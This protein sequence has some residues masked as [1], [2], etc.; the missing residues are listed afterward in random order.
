MYRIAQA[1]TFRLEDP[2]ILVSKQLLTAEP[3]AVGQD[4]IQG[5]IN[6]AER[7]L[8]LIN[9]DSDGLMAAAG[10]PAC[11]HQPTAG[12]RVIRSIALAG[13]AKFSPYRSCVPLDLGVSPQPNHVAPA[14]TALKPAEQ[15]GADAGTGVIQSFSQQQHGP[16]ELHIEALIWSMPVL[17]RQQQEAPGGYSCLLGAVKEFIQEWRPQ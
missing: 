14:R 10:W 17:D 16:A 2:R 9:G 3:L 5:G 13:S 7:G 4:Q 11:C 6:F 12:H 1:N 15:L 8:G